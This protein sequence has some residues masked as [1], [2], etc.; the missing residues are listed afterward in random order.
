MSIGSI[1]GGGES[2]MVRNFAGSG[3]GQSK[4]IKASLNGFQ[5]EKEAGNKYMGMVDTLMSE[6]SS[7]MAKHPRGG[8]ALINR[9]S[10][11]AEAML[12]RDRQEEVVRE[13]KVHLDKSKEELERATEEAMAPKDEQGR[14]IELAGGSVGESVPAPD[15][16]AA[17][18]GGGQ[19]TRA[20]PPLYGAG[21][22]P[23]ETAAPGGSAAPAPPAPSVDIT[24]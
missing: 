7:E 2:L 10:K 21:G 17:A 11:R 20:Q 16:P 5:A 23:V 19:P 8:N 3:T 6:I 15:I 4:Y 1:S 22:L 24:V 14:P 13:A 12:E 18:P 9:I